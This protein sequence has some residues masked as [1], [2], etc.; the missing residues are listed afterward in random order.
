MNNNTLRDELV[1][2]SNILTL[3]IS[4]QDWK[5]GQRADYH[6]Q[7]AIKY[8]QSGMETRADPWMFLTSIL[9]VTILVHMFAFV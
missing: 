6:L 7:H 1:R 9:K 8:W 4:L 2:K 3:M 5:R